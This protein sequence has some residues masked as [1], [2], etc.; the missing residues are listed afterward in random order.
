MAEAAI[1]GVT[2]SV[3]SLWNMASGM[4]LLFLPQRK[5]LWGGGHQACIHHRE[6]G[7]RYVPTIFTFELSEALVSVGHQ[8]S[9]QFVEHGVG[10]VSTTFA[11]E[12]PPTKPVSI[13]GSMASGMFLL[14]RI[15]GFHDQKFEKIY[16]WKKCWY[17]IFEEEKLLSYPMKAVK[18]TGEAFSP[19]KRTFSTSKNEIFQL[20]S[21]FIGH[22]CPTGSG[23]GFWIRIQFG[24]GSE[25][26]IHPTVTNVW[27]THKMPS[28]MYEVN[29]TSLGYT[30]H[31]PVWKFRSACVKGREL[32]GPI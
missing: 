11:G 19:Q 5:R 30:L 4:F 17:S 23:F 18:A 29:Y 32:R 22:F 13:R 26:L 9:L 1:N 3:S 6:H 7:V 25:T 31:V 2:K 14:L 16:S 8:V 28:K 10:Y 15:H 20:F 12:L 27:D 21:I 24:S